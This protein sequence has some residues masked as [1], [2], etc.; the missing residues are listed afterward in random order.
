MDFPIFA[1]PVIK[2]GDF[3]LSQTPAI[4]KYLGKEFG[5][6]P[7]TREDEAHADQMI[8]F[9]T[10]FVAEGRLVFHSK[11]FTMSYY[12]QIEETKP[13]IAWFESERLPKVLK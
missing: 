7:R 11:C 2:K 6:Y 1:P 5:L 3:V 10:D 4:M 12:Q 13:N 8:A 9:V